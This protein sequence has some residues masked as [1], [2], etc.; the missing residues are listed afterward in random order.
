MKLFYEGVLKSGVI[1]PWVSNVCSRWR[2]PH[3][4]FDKSYISFVI[5]IKFLPIFHSR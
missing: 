5:I 1:A 3:N 2:S 4:C